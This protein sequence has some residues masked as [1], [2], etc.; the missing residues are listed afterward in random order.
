[1]T[2]DEAITEVKKEG[3]NIGKLVNETGD[4][5]IGKKFSAYKWVEELKES[6][7]GIA[8]VDVCGAY[9]PD[10]IPTLV[11]I[12]FEAGRRY[13]IAQAEVESLERL[14]GDVK[15][16]KKGRTKKG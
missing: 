2:F 13:G 14:V 3:R 8:L 11:C 12:A 16:S 7:E 10:A 5:D 15:P 6:R 1:M 9:G 4:W